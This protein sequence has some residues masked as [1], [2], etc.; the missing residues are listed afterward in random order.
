MALPYIFGSGTFI[1]Q[2]FFLQLQADFDALSSGQIPGTTTNDSA[3]AGNIGEYVES[4]V[5]QGAPLS[6]T[7]GVP[8]NLTSISLSSGDWDIRAMGYFSPNAATVTTTAVASIGTVSATLD[9]TPGRV[10]AVTIPAGGITGGS[11][12]AFPIAPY[13]FSL[14][15]PMTI[16]FVVLAIFTVNIMSSFGI[17][18]ARRIR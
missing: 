3:A 1:S 13:R 15:V 17:I 11:G 10:T 18:S 6:L 7:S 2:L 9:S 4:I 16:F 14:A 12:Y 5:L 8:I